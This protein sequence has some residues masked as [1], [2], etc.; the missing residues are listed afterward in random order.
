MEPT[1]E[2]GRTARLEGGIAVD[3]CRSIAFLDRDDTISRDYPD[4]EWVGK[5]EPELLAGAPEAMA[6]LQRLGYELILVTNQYIIGEGFITQQ[7]FERFHQRLLEKLE[8]FGVSVL[9]T[10][11]CPH[12][13][14]SGCGCC[15]PEPGLILQAL[16]K[17]PD[18][19]LS[20]SFLAGDSWRDRELA[21]R[22]SL[23]FYG[24]NMQ[25]SDYGQPVASLWEAAECVARKQEADHES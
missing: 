9:D 11:F 7:D 6:R 22:F 16:A 21:R 23:E 17:Y 8:A 1:A 3:R 12:S 20:R 18:I 10:F 25:E 14:G 24:V 2:R 15:K 4:G 5:R 19:D 13:R